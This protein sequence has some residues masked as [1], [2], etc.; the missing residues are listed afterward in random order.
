MTTSWRDVW[1]R[2]RLDPTRGSVL[3]QLLAADGFDSGAGGVDEAAWRHFIGGVAETLEL[4]EDE[5]VFDVGCGAGAFTYPL[6]QAGCRVGGI[7]QSEALIAAARQV[8]P[9]GHWLVGD[10]ASLD[11]AEPA[12]VVVAC[13]SFLYFPDHEYA[14]GVLARMTSKATRAV[15]ILDVPDVDFREEALQL[16]R[17]TL[18]ADEYE[19]RYR[20]LD[21]LY[22]DRLWFLRMLDQ[23]G[24]SAIQIGQQRV[25]GYRMGEYRFNVFARV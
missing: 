8:M 18:G 12:D 24:A 10:A 14:R 4:R 3:A 2:R 23:M 22:F 19:A 20:G 13:G 21:H 25:E 1:A 6:Q 5:S 9:E 11:P 7:D 15:A 16:R 17:G